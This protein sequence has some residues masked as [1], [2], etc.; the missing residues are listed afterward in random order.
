MLHRSQGPI[1]F[2]QPAGCLMLSRP[3]PLRDRMEH[4][5]RPPRRGRPWTASDPI[6]GLAAAR[7]PGPVPAR[8]LPST[9][10]A[11]AFLLTMGRWKRVCSWWLFTAEELESILATPWNL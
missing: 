4:R 1:V 10:P 7:P 11:D 9:D 6:D 8:P 5:R 3:G 2:V